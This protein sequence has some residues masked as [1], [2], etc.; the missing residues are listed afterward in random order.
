MTLIKNS[1][2]I[3]EPFLIDDEK[4]KN[5]LNQLEI[6][7][8][9]QEGLKRISGGFAKADI[10]DYDDNFFDVTLKFGIQSDCENVVYTE[11]YTLDRLTLRISD[12]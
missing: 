2:E 5:A 3:P 7:T 4:V 9:N 10:F 12:S 8:V 11:Q 6:D 1:Q